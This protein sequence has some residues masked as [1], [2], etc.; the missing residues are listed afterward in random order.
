MAKIL[1][2]FYLEPKQCK[3][4]EKESDK[5]GLSQAEIVRKLIEEKSK[6]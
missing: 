1:K 2:Q 3:W 6:K 5:T 4:L